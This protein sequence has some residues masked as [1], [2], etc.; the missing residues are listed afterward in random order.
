MT[1]DPETLQVLT[2]TALMNMEGEGLNDLREYNRKKLVQMGVLK[3]TDEEA[4]MMAAQAGEKS[5]NDKA[6]EGMA[7]EAEAKA[8]KARVEVVKTLA[9]VE[10]IKADVEKIN[11]ETIE[12]LAG[13]DMAS[14]DQALAIAEKLSPKIEAAP[15]GEGVDANG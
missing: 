4:Q 6:L 1:Q 2:A 5:A 11:A 9:E 8:T 13:V 3:P 15:M 10:K 12:T 14:T 7:A